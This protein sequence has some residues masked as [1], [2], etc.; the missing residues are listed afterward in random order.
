MVGL[1]A[2]RLQLRRRIKALHYLLKTIDV[3]LTKSKPTAPLSQLPTRESAFNPSER[4]ESNSETG[5]TSPIRTK[6]PATSTVTVAP[7]ST[8]LRRACRIALIESDRPQSCEQILQRIRRRESVCI[9]DFQDP[10]NAITKELGEMLA[11]GE[12]IQKTNDQLWQL[13]R[14]SC[15]CIGRTSSTDK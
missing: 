3:E 14:D 6:E 11:D 7:D 1:H 13:N 2:S 12:V 9:E 4:R 15:R 10:L 5:A 8:E